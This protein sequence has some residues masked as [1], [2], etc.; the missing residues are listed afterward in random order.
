MAA[1][2]MNG[3]SFEGRKTAVHAASSGRP[4][5]FGGCRAQA[6]CMINGSK[7]HMIAQRK[8]TLRSQSTAAQ[9]A[10]PR[11]GKATD[12]GA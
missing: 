2:L 11:P 1:A 8:H 10:N 3:A 6:I 4:I 12:L 9:S 7:D 5:R